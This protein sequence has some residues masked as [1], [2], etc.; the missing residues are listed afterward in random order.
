MTRVVVC[1]SHTRGNE[2]FV[3]RTLDR[4]HAERKFTDLM[5]GGAEYVDRFAKIWCS[6]HPEIE[7]WQFNAEWSKFGRQGGPIRNKRMID[8]RPDLV[9][10]FDGDAGTANMVRQARDAG[11]EVIEIKED[12]L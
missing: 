8:W 2:D 1:G 5:Q 12:Q 9:V 4:I 7:P 3:Y 11:I 10:A 6:F